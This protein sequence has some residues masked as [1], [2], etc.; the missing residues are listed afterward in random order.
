MKRR[1]AHDERR[2]GIIWLIGGVFLLAL[3]F[4]A[5]WLVATTNS[6]GDHDAQLLPLLALIPLLIGTYHM[7]KTRHHAK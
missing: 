3:M 5:W 6:E 2:L 7:I 4:G 1:S